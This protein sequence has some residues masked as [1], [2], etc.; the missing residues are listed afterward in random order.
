MDS[1][2]PS[3]P[4]PR[5]SST[6]AATSSRVKLEL[7][8]SLI[9]TPTSLSTAAATALMTTITGRSTVTMPQTSGASTSAARSGP[10]SAMFLG[11][12]SPST[13]CR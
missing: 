3:R 9:R 13:T 5:D 8:S 10:A 4:S 11:T 2:S 6:I 12:I 1:E 7:T